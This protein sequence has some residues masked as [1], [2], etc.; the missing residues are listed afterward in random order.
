[1]KKRLRVDK[2]KQ[3][4]F[5]S[6]AEVAILSCICGASVSLT[7]S[8]IN[9][10]LPIKNDGRKINFTLTLS[11][12]DVVCEVKEINHAKKVILFSLNCV[13]PVAY[14]SFDDA[15]EKTMF[16]FFSGD[17]ILER[18]HIKQALKNLSDIRNYFCGFNSFA[19]YENRRFLMGLY[20]IY[21]EIEKVTKRSS[22][23]LQRVEDIND[24]V[25]TEQLSYEPPIVGPQFKKH[26]YE[27]AVKNS[28]KFS[29][30]DFSVLN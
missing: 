21:S 28:H 23:S 26:S 11:D 30:D 7:N 8:S 5:I 13:N 29:V 19:T 27:F 18:Q 2:F 4:L 12:D 10:N 25:S 17:V 16:D 9:F 20:Q 3:E 6:K 22:I 1:M 24:N 14:K 15:Y